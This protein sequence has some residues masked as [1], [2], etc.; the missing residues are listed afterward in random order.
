M[1]IKNVKGEKIVE[2]VKNFDH[3]HHKF[4]FGQ[5][6]CFSVKLKMD[7]NLKFRSKFNH[8]FT[9]HVYVHCA[10]PKSLYNF[11]VK[12]AHE[13][14]DSQFLFQNVQNKI[15]EIFKMLKKT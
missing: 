8:S 3:Y 2:Y 13:A 12:R 5:F 9:N 10:I 6:F 15:F 11:M 7:L 14:R 1:V 4:N